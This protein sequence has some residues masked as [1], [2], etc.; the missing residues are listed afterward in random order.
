M[1]GK[2]SLL[3]KFRLRPGGSLV[4]GSLRLVVLTAAQ[5]LP[6][7]TVI[8]LLAC[9]HRGDD[10]HDHSDD[11]DHMVM[12]VAMITKLKGG[13]ALPPVHTQKGYVDNEE[14]SKQ[15]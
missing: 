5:T 7:A 12:M 3:S 9:H 10:D 1:T 13:G 15:P 2:D 14:R 6:P 4:H 8:L 11:H